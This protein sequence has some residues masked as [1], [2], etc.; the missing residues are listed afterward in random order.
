MLKA[1]MKKMPLIWAGSIFMVS[2][3]IIFPIILK[4]TKPIKATKNSFD[5]WR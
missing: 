5:L 3:R 4:A 1:K 2:A